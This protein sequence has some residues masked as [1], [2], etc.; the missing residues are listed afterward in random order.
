MLRIINEKDIPR[1][2]EAYIPF[3]EWQHTSIQIYRTTMIDS[4]QT[5]LEAT[6]LCTHVSTKFYM[7]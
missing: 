3:T 5:I 1:N 7:K 2:D 6:E 4:V